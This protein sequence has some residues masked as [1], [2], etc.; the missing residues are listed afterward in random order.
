MGW[1][2]VGA[3]L[4]TAPPVCA[5]GEAPEEVVSAVAAAAER[6]GWGVVRAARDAKTPRLLLVRV[7]SRWYARSVAERRRHAQEWLDR[8]RHSV[9][10]G[11]LAV[12]DHETDAPVVR[13]GPGARV[14]GVLE[15]APVHER[16]DATP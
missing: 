15:A 1:T 6:A 10:H 4:L 5:H 14:V 16:G 7:G 11:L 9:P 8:W 13:F 2:L 12:L 3:L